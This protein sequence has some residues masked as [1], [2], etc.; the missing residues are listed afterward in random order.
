MSLLTPNEI[1]TQYGGTGTFDLATIQM[2]IDLAQFDLEDALAT[3]L[4]PTTVVEEYMW[5]AGTGQD[6]ILLNK[7]HVSSIESVVAKYSLLWDCSWI[8][9]NECGVIL[10]GEQGL[11]QVKAVNYSL[12][13]CQ[14]TNIASYSMVSRVVPD[15]LLITYIAGYTAAESDPSTAVGKVLRMATTLRAREW[16]NALSQ[17]QDWQ[18]NYNIASWNSMD[19]SE[20][21]VYGDNVNNQ[22][23]PGPMS[24]EVARMI[25]RLKPY[26][27]IFLRSSGRI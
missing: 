20:R 16:F 23:G 21:R 11:V 27:G 1:A 2:G 17:G 6:K 4:T 18:G 24:Q 5:P 25:D 26:R 10:D 22:L 3:Y 13:I 9:S 14:C 7:S 19:Y 12:N 8:Q 15:R